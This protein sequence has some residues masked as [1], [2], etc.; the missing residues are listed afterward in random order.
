MFNA[1]ARGSA[2]N[3]KHINFQGEFDFIKHI[4]ANQSTFDIEKILT[5]KVA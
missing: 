1:I 2:T 4:A 3:W 5:L